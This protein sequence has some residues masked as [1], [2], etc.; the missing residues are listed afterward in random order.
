MSF[1]GRKT[2]Y[3]DTAIQRKAGPLYFHIYVIEINLILQFT[4]C[5]KNTQVGR[6]SSVFHKYVCKE[7]KQRKTNLTVKNLPIN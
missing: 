3:S 1:R 2:Y 5:Y 4:L 7:E 6:N